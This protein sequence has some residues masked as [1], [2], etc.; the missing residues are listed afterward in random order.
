MAANLYFQA[1]CF[2]YG[3]AHLPSLGYELQSLAFLATATIAKS[4]K[5]AHDLTNA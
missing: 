1:R 5:R 3:R 2:S 4:H